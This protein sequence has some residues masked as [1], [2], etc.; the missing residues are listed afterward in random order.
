M[1]I[2]VLGAPNSG[3]TQLVHDLLQHLTGAGWSA[4]I[5]DDTSH[6]LSPSHA[7]MVWILDAPAI[8]NLSAH[9]FDLYLLMGLDLPSPAIASANVDMRLR[10]QLNKAQLAYHVVYGQ[11]A[12]RLQ[13]ALFALARQAP[14]LAMPMR[15]EQPARWLGVCESCGDGPCEHR[16][17]S[18]LL[19]RRR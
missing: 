17:F 6:T 14:T 3:K 12:E 19:T 5:A 8:D 1:H 4:A 18:T 13:S 2:A 16:L 7:A 10:Q 9:R 15:A 11:G